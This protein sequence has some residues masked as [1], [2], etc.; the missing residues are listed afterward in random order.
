MNTGRYSTP[1]AANT[2]PGWTLTTLLTPS[3]LF[4]ANGM[5]IGPD[6]E[7]YVAQAFGSQISA[8]DPNSGSARTAV[9]VGSA[10]IGRAHV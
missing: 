1:V 6:G 7:L 5:K 8:L 10:E 3:P 2:A 4:G 9:P